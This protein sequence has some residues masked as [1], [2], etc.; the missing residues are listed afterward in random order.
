MSITYQ[1][2]TEFGFI[3]D[4]VGQRSIPQ[5]SLLM[6]NLEVRRG[7][8]GVPKPSL[9]AAPDFVLTMAASKRQAEQGFTIARDMA[10]VKLHLTIAGLYN[11]LTN[12]DSVFLDRFA[13]LPPHVAQH[14]VS[15]K[16]LTDKRPWQLIYVTSTSQA[17]SN[18]KRFTSG[19]TESRIW[20]EVGD[21]RCD[22]IHTVPGLLYPHMAPARVSMSRSQVN[23]RLA[24]WVFHYGLKRRLRLPTVRLEMIH[25]STW[26]GIVSRPHVGSRTSK[27]FHRTGALTAR[28]V[29]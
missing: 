13:D 5:L 20:Q 19:I 3:C 29:K 26:R 10:T 6:A 11:R 17:H 4:L 18:L 23:H 14:A 1:T 2:K 27:L 24:N 16:C 9:R 28:P 12:P 7:G 15:T 8:L 25:R 21:N 22:Q